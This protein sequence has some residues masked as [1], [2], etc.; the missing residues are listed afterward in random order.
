L[1]R[2]QELRIELLLFDEQPTQFRD[3][4]RGGDGCAQLLAM[5]NS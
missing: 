4:H 1:A 2:N 5:A 3:G